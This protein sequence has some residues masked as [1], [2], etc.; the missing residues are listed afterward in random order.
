MNRIRIEYDESKCIAAEACVK[1]DPSTF[2]FD[3]AKQK[4]VLIGS[5]KTGAS[6]F[7]LELMGDAQRIKNAMEAASSCPVNAYKVV[8]LDSGKTAVS[9]SLDTQ[10]LKEIRA[11]YDDSTQFTL[12]P[13]GYFLI[14]VNYEKKEIEAGFCNERN[15]MVLKVVG[16]KPIDIYHEIAK[17]KLGLH[18]EHYSYL[19]RELEKAYHCVM[20][21]LEYVQDDELH[22]MK[23]RRK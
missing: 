4:A 22:T 23:S 5:K 9:N 15:S 8:E 11:Q 3:D 12:D 7:V 14:R 2:G 17:Q 19:G 13:K 16:T 1:S 6:T 20:T 21:G 10:N 18:E